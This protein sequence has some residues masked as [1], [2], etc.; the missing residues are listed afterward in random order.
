MP[1]L[2]SVTHISFSVRDL[3]TSREWYQRV[4]G[5]KTLVPPFER[6]HY[7]ETILLAG[8]TG[9]CLQ[10]HFDNS[11]DEF[12][13]HR[14]GLDHLAFRVETDDE[15]EAWLAHFDELGVR[16]WPQGQGESFGRMVVFRDPD[17]I[18]LELHCDARKR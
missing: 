18:Q 14:T 7:K 4:L 10:Q 17:N 15:F 9:L 3:E 1:K 8:N 12:S 5:L 11:G 13:E 2:G 6:E 16:Y